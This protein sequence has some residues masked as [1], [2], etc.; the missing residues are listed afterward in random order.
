MFL[1]ARRLSDN[2]TARGTLIAVKKMPATKFPLAF[3]LSAAD[4]PFQNG[5][6]DGEL[7]LTARINQ[8]GD[9]MTHQK[10]DVLGTL[11]KVRVGSQEREA[12]ARSGPEGDGVA[13]GAR[14]DGRRPS[15]DDARRPA[16]R[17]SGRSGAAAGTSVARALVIRSAAMDYKKLRDMVSHRVTFE[18]DSGSKVVG[19]VAS[20]LP[21]SG[22]VQMLVLS[23]VQVFDGSKNVIARYDELPAGPE[24]PRRLPDHRRSS[25]RRR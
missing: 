4:M 24:Q 21:P 2:P 25:L 6:F 16:A 19:Y 15:A 13:R 18:Y 9:P 3:D 5:A 7:T 20:C 10:G 1:V 11:P 8:D 12:D 17:A 23:K 22:A 14:A